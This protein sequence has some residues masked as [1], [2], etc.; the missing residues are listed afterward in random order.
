MPGAALSCRTVNETNAVIY[1]S[2]REVTIENGDPLSEAILIV[3]DY[4]ESPGLEITPVIEFLS[5]IASQ[6]EAMTAS[7]C[8]EKLSGVKGV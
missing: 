6:S 8:I 7:N 1:Q 5:G 3:V 4:E 2:K